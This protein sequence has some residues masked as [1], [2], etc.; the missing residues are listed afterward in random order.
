MPRRKLDKF[1]VDGP[2]YFPADGTG[3]GRDDQSFQ[4]F[5]SVDPASCPATAAP[6]CES[7][8][9]REPPLTGP[10]TDATRPNIELFD[11]YALSGGI[12]RESGR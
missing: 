4:D 7:Y 12:G 2:E 11:S 1:I 3:T 6:G 8:M 10:L 9:P 5:Q